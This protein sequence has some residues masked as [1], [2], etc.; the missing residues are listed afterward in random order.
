[1][2]GVLS[3]RGVGPQTLQEMWGCKRWHVVATY[4]AVNGPHV[5]TRDFEELEEVDDWIEM[6][7]H[8][9]ALLDIRITLQR[10]S[11]PGYILEA[12]HDFSLADVKRSLVGGRK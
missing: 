9:C 5:L 7:P 1:M 2:S 10:N 11:R 8:W 4:R 12:D 6:G 3:D